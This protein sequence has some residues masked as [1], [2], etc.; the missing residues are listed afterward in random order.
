MY[1]TLIDK[2]LEHPLWPEPVRI[3]RIAK[4]GQQYEVLSE[5]LRSQ[6]I[7]KRLLS[8]EVVAELNRHVAAT[9]TDF[10]GDPK[11]F[12]LGVEARRIKLGHTF[13]PYF[14]ISTSLVDPLPH[15]LEAVYG[16]LLKKPQIRFLLADDPGAGKTIMGGLLLK[17]L[18]FRG[19]LERV[20]IVTPANLT[21]Q[22]RRE[23]KEKF[24]ERFEVLNRETMGALYDEN[25][26][27]ARPYAI[28]SLDFAKREPYLS[29]LEHAHWDL[30]IID[31]AHKLSA[32]RY[33]DEVKKS[34][35]YRLGETLART[36]AQLLLLTATP[37]QGDDEKFRLLLNLLEPD[38]FATTAL[39]EEASQAGEN[40]VM[41]RRLKEDMVDFEG[42][43]LFPPRFVHTPTFKLTP[44]ERILYEKVTEYV[45]KH[46][47]AAWV[48]KKRN[49]GLAMTVLQRRLASSS[50]AIARSLENRLKRLQTLREDLSQL[51]QVDPLLDLTEEELEDLPEEERWRIETEAAERLT[52]AQNLP[53]L[54]REIRELET[55]SRE[56][57][58]LSHFEQ[59]RKLTELFKVL[60]VLGGEKLLIFTEHKDTLNF[61]VRILTKRGVRVTSIDGSLRLEERVAREREFRDAAQVM[62]ATEAAGE[63]IN[64]Q[65]CSVMVNY[66]LPWNRNPTR[67]EQRMG[68]IHR[69][70]QKFDVHIYNLV[71]EGTREGDVLGTLLHKLEA[72]RQ[73]LG[74]DR[75]YDVVDDLLGDVN[76]EHLVL[77][78]LAGR[79][80]LSE[81]RAVIEA[82]VNPERIAF[83]KEVT[84]EAL[85]ER[86]IDLSRLRAQKEHSDL[87]RLQPEYIQRFFL[88]AFVRL[89]GVTE[90]RQDR[91]WR[92][93]IPYELRQKREG[94]GSE[95]LRAS[96][97][98]T[99]SDAE[100][101]APGHLLFDAVLDQTL[102]DSATVLS[103]GAVF[104]LPNLDVPGPLGHLELT[105]VDGTGQV[106]SKRL[107][108]G[109]AP[110]DT[111]VPKALPS[112]V[113][114]DAAPSTDVPKDVEVEMVQSQLR[115]WVH[116][117]VLDKFF[118]EVRAERGREVAIRR[119]YR[120]K[121]LDYLIRESTKKLTQYKVKARQGDA[122]D[123]PILLE[124]R[125][126]KELRERKESLLRRL[127]GEA[128]LFP[129]PAEL[130]ALAYA[131]PATQEGS[132]T[133]DDPELRRKV[134]LAAMATV[135]AYEHEQGRNPKDVSAENVGFD[136][137]S[138]GRAVEVKGKA[139][140]GAIILTPNEWI[141]ASRLGDAYYLYIVTNALTNP[142]LHI[143]HNPAQ[144]IDP[145][146]EQSVVRYVVPDQV[147]RGA[148]D[149]A[150]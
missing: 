20:L 23:L 94:L 61:L 47:K 128:N 2:L 132:L 55:L 56:A 29:Q 110:V 40:P 36:S 92:L 5:G 39:L 48:Q 104:E 38:L 8:S 127:E 76:L 87:Q 4:L 105:I 31:E 21:D 84:A 44:S 26:W 34:Q 28:T 66:D 30:V 101:I 45:S 118:E 145:D 142:A 115:D 50:Y 106:V 100:L 97:R 130:F 135:I 15:Q 43:P 69:Y 89:G 144:K 149:R 22:W 116:E 16:H 52:L 146:E 111:A 80:S 139:A 24:G 123:L 96:F 35:R 150:E 75:V 134:E 85:A 148:A 138:T 73:Q 37:H 17:E 77:D 9:A 121:S 1:Q 125:R 83:I 99:A 68:R 13:D 119:K 18:K 19:L 11:L 46:F 112:Q 113:L 114:V 54:E 81:I 7:L 108:A 63:G 133:E 124:E 137:Q 67:L 79:K 3:L 136:V 131:Y 117:T 12:A 6:T 72:M 62:V 122:M 120:L 25:P 49:V 82:R 51:G 143:V 64:L 41:L 53:M 71:A 42:K 14:A 57:K 103:K 90:Q 33:G 60:E 10:A 78:H 98:K 95:I 147:W 88:E 59:D 74:S 70:G 140:T 32:T 107:I 86:T 91:L 109:I 93:K 126:L 27:L 102:K 65:F 58:V 129:Q 141:T